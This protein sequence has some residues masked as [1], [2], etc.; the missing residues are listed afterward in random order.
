MNTIITSRAQILE[1]ACAL[2][3]REGREAL[4]IRGVAAACGISVGSVYN[5]FPSKTDL[6]VAVLEEIWRGIF[7]CRVTVNAHADNI[8]FS[9][10]VQALF[11]QVRKGTAAYPSFFS[12]H[13][14]GLT[15]LEQE[16]G[17]AT[18]QQYFSHI[19]RGLLQTL[20]SDPAVRADAFGPALTQEAFV[21]F[22]FTHILLLLQTDSPDCD[23]L[24]AI[25]ARVL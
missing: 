13:T 16:K 10:A 3:A 12:T 4:T 7:H 2:A 19:K 21:H 8:R 22:V 20:L 14:A 17:R 5:Y 18:M 23:T 15:A 6:T 1:T 24:L 9:E 25:I 11:T